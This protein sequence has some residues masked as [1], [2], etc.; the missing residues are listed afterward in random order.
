[1]QSFPMNPDSLAGPVVLV[2]D[3]GGRWSL[4]RKRLDL[5]VVRR[6]AKD[7]DAVVIWGDMGGISPRALSEAERGEVWAQLKDAYAGPGGKPDGRY[8]GHEFR[9]D[10]GWRMLYVEDHC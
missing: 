10:D 5:R 9:S 7:R 4:H 6:L 8:L 2:D 3:G 1:M